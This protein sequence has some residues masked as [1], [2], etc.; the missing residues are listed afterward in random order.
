MIISQYKVSPYSIENSSGSAP[1]PQTIGALFTP[2][3]SSPDWTNDTAGAM[4]VSFNSDNIRLQG[5]SLNE[6]GVDNQI[7]FKNYRTN[8]ENYT[9]SGHF[10]VNSIGALDYGVAIILT[11]DPLGPEYTI[12]FALG[13]AAGVNLG[14]VL[15]QIFGEEQAGSAYVTNIPLLGDRIDWEIVVNK[16]TITWRCKN[17]TPLRVDPAWT[18]VPYTYSLVYASPAKIFPSSV[19]YGIRMYGGDVSVYPSSV[20]T[21]DL[22]RSI[23]LVTDSKGK[24]YFQ[25]ALLNRVTDLL[26][27]ANP[28]L[29]IYNNSG[30]NE[31]S[32]H[33]VLRYAE[34]AKYLPTDIAWILHS[35]DLRPPSAITHQETIDN[36]VDFNDTVCVPLGIRFC[37]MQPPLENP[38]GGQDLSP[39]YTVAAEA[40]IPVENRISAATGV[41][42]VTENASDGYHWLNTLALKVATRLADF[43]GINI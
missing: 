30:A 43:Y 4:T 20:N 38:I 42:P 2:T 15:I 28:T 27:A 17:V 25:A 34:F 31:R 29:R 23:M 16:T 18:E 3:T 41:D 13:T 39:L 5:G 12:R 33:P 9:T 35:N 36:V 24:G 14:K 37:V 40:G 19:R 11:S 26:Q 22:T 6:Y 1:A 32:S 10:I 7:I 8:S 21:T